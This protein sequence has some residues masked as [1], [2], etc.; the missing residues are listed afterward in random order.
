MEPL[1]KVSELKVGFR[2]ERGMLCAVD[3]VSFEVGRKEKFGI[4]GESGCGKSVTALSLLRLIPDPPGKILAGKIFFNGED[5]L[6]LPLSRLRSIRGKKISMIFQ[7]PVA[8]LNPV[9]TAGSQVAE[10][11][12]VHEK[13]PRAEAWNRAVDMLKLVRIPDPERRAHEYPHQLSGGMCQRAMIAMALALNPELLIADEPTTALDVTIQA[14]ILELINELSEKMGMSLILITHDL[15]VIAETVQR[16][17]V[18]YTGMAVESASTGE[19][20]ANPLHPYTRGLMEA[21]P[22]KGLEKKAGRKQRLYTIPGMVPSPLDL[23]RGCPFQE[24][25][26]LVKTHCRETLPPFEQKATGHWVRC[27]EVK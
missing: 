19:I 7:E 22:G 27:F 3:N 4:I 26:S 14:Q 11:F 10:V 15:G 16:V 13:L 23:P 1:L 21:M 25:C 17:M 12:R 5:I 8:S 9:F 18:M 24:R 20:F 2:V 6:A